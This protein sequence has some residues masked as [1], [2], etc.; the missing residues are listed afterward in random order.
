MF[1]A[2]NIG[3]YP[4]F[5]SQYPDRPVTLI[6]PY[7]AGGAADL[8][9]RTLEKPFVLKLDQPLIINNIA[10][11]GGMAAWNELAGAKPDGY[12]LG[13][14]SMVLILQPL[15]GETRYHYAT[16]LDPIAQVVSYPIVL[17]VPRRS[18]FG[19]ISMILSN[20]RKAIPAKLNSPTPARARLTIFS[21]SFSPEKP[22]LIL[23]RSPSAATPR[24]W[25]RC[26]AAILILPLSHR[27]Q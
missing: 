17:A 14:T 19:K 21:A 10:G 26:S 3:K 7:T 5:A 18:A 22:A 23:S 20:T 1:L 13:I 8:V 12:T 27:Q 11:A 25:P 15:Y 4:L 24:V 6:V 2:A 16:A 9:A